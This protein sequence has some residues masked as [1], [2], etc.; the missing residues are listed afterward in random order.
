MEKEKSLF[1]FLLGN[2]KVSRHATQQFGINHLIAHFC[3]PLWDRLHI[4]NHIRICS[5]KLHCTLWLTPLKMVK[6]SVVSLNLL[7]TKPLW[8]QVEKQSI[9]K[10]SLM[11]FLSFRGTLIR[12]II[13]TWEED[14][15]NFYFATPSRLQI[16]LHSNYACS[17]SDTICLCLWLALCLDHNRQT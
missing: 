17:D 11:A 3:A 4:V 13:A 9:T 1:F 14:H 15:I 6:L 16:D 7:E 10:E 5:T 8:T 12:F 2:S